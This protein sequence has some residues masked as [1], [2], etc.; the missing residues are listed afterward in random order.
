MARSG[1]GHRLWSVSAETARPAAR[2]GGHGLAH[3]AG[4][5]PVADEERGGAGLQ[6]GD[7]ELDLVRVVFDLGAE[8]LVQ[9]AR[10]WP[11]PS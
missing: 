11:A 8:V 2:S 1:T 5:D 7:R 9:L 6:V 3:R 4:G 10:P